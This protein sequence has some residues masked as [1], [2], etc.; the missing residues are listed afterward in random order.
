VML[1]CLPL[2]IG[3]VDSDPEELDDSDSIWGVDVGT[4]QLVV[5]GSTW[6]SS[7]VICACPGEAPMPVPASWSVAPDGVV[8]LSST[9]G[10]FAQITGLTAGTAVLTAR[11]GTEST[12]IT[13][14][15]TAP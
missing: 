9:H 6:A 5:G 7:N 15:V 8:S 1:A 12:T 10:T 11:S 4:R 3:C 14:N 13:F 2:I